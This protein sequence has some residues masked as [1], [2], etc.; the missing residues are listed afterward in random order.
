YTA[1]GYRLS[2]LP[3][4]PALWTRVDPPVTARDPAEVPGVAAPLLDPDE[5]APAAPLAPKPQGRSPN[6]GPGSR[7][8]S[9]RRPHRPSHSQRPLFGHPQA[10]WALGVRQETLLEDGKKAG[11]LER[12]LQLGLAYTWPGV[13]AATSVAATAKLWDDE[14]VGDGSGLAG[15]GQAV[16]LGVGR[17]QAWPV[18][19]RSFALARGLSLAGFR[20]GAD[21][22]RQGVVATWR[23]QAA[24][25]W[26]LGRQRLVLDGVVGTASLEEAL[27][28]GD[29]TASRAVDRSLWT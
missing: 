21:G 2:L 19:G 3:F 5:P 17:E 27:A 23:E 4:S 6:P 26:N 16:T 15:P 24:F 22:S 10:T 9:A 18:D 1:R 7:S 28:V 13:L 25:S 20:E 29:P 12:E 8:S 11:R 14:P